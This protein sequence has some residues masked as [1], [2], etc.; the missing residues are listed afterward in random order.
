[1][2]LQFYKRDVDVAVCKASEG[3]PP[4]IFLEATADK[5]ESKE[6][7]CSLELIGTTEECSFLLTSPKPMSCL[8]VASSQLSRGKTVPV[9]EKLLQV[10]YCDF[11]FF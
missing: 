10:F 11:I 7:E 4:R 6:L 9:V 5:C 2:P 3:Y 1:M 8:A